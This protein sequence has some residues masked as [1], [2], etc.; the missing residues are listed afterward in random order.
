VITGASSGIGKALA[1][2]LAARGYALGLASRRIARLEEL[3]DAL[4]ATHPGVKVE[5]AELDVDQV[6]TVKACLADLFTRMGGADIVVVNAGVN[7]FTRVGRD[8]LAD[9]LQILQTNVLGAVAT[10]QAASAYFLSRGRGQLVGISSLAAENAIPKQAAYC[11]SKAALSM[12]LD[13]ARMELS[14]KGIGVTTILPGFVETDG[15][16]PFAVSAEKAATEIA[17]IIE[18]GAAVGVVPAFPWKY[19]KPFF[20]VIPDAVYRKLK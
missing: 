3:R 7:R 5:L 13:I 10:I 6:D 1:F 9:E 16:Y 18:R 2:E 20:K 17:N 12:Y 19:V 8:E 4:H 11:A 15:K 14:R